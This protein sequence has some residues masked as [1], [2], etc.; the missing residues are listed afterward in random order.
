MLIATS[1]LHS[2]LKTMD[3]I[4][5][6]LIE[7]IPTVDIPSGPSLP[8]QFDHELLLNSFV[9]SSI[10]SDVEIVFCFDTTGSMAT[11][12]H[13]VR[14][15][16]EATVSRLMSDIPNIR[17][18]IMGLGDYSDG[19]D[20][21][22]TLDLTRDVDQLVS[23]INSVPNTSGG[24]IPEAYEWALKKAKDLSWST[25]TSKAFVMIGDSNPHEPSHTNLKINW[26]EACDELYD[27]GIK[28]Y[29]VKA[30]GSSIFYEEIAQRTGGLCINFNNF[31]L[32]TEMFLAICY[33]EASYEKFKKYERELISPNT[34]SSNNNN[35][36]N[37][38]SSDITA[39]LSDLNQ[40]NFT[41]VE[42]KDTAASPTSIKP[43]P[44]NDLSSDSNSNSNNN[45]NNNIIIKKRGYPTRMRSNED[46]FNHSLD[47]TTYPTFMYSDTLGYFVRNNPDV[48]SKPGISDAPHHVYP[49]G[50]S[51]LSMASTIF[52]D[53][54]RS[55]SKQMH[56]RPMAVAIVGDNHIGK[57]TFVNRINMFAYGDIVLEEFT[58]HIRANQI[59]KVRAYG[60]C[61]DVSNANSYKNVRAYLDVITTRDRGT[62]IFV[63]ALKSDIVDNAIGTPVYE[64][65]EYTTTGYKII[66]H[67]TH[68]NNASL[69]EIAERIKK[70][71]DPGMPVTKSSC[72]L[73]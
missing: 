61:F 30:L 6:L 71:I 50:T 17:I 66:G 33:R 60:V 19:K 41:V 68:Q 9:E 53:D 27:I 32:I 36:N 42:T 46:W 34:G 58:P 15:Q 38:S 64:L 5:L 45:N 31:K 14:Q 3:R 73:M 51:S 44:L 62:P 39:I 70:T 54:C 7:K 25:Y 52:A 65:N 43:S 12:V 49:D 48:M 16:V 10:S 26:F 40:A 37:N 69:K 35:S 56:R 63:V 55:M 8:E 72:S 13:T 22:T 67:S 57:T 11:I 24:D 59:G 1:S 23:F 18:G 47:K 21:L 4:D 29:G 28:V 20:V 2:C